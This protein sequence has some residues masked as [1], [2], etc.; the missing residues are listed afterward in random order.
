MAQFRKKPVIIEAITFNELIEFGKENC[1]A[2]DKKEQKQIAT[3]G[4]KLCAVS[5]AC[6]L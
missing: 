1:G 5:V 2:W 6:A 3:N 4:I